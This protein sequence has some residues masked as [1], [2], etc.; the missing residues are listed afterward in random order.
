LV[1][2]GDTWSSWETLAFEIH[3]TLTSANVL[4]HW[5]HDLG[6]YF[7]TEHNAEIWLR[8]LQYGIFSPVFRTHCDQCCSCEPW[9]Y[10][11]QPLWVYA[12]NLRNNLHP[13]IYT[14]AYNSYRTGITM[15]YPMYYDYP[16]VEQAYYYQYQYFFWSRNARYSYCY[17]YQ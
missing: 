17:P 10:D 12:F 7:Q 3:L 4:T 15:A 11:Y 13:Y 16:T 6:A 14:L 1:G 2:S 9:D 5:T 8:W